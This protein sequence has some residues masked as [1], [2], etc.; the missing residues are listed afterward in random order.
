MFLNQISKAQQYPT[1]FL[2]EL[3]INYYQI[4]IEG[5]ARKGGHSGNAYICSH[6]RPRSLIKGLASCW[7]CTVDIF[8][9][10]FSNFSNHFSWA[11]I[12][13][14]KCF[15]WDQKKLQIKSTNWFYKWE[16]LTSFQFHSIHE[17]RRNIHVQIQ[18]QVHNLTMILL[19]KLVHVCITVQRVQKYFLLPK[20][21]ISPLHFVYWNLQ[22]CIS[23]HKNTFPILIQTC[24]NKVRFGVFE[25]EVKHVITKLV[26][27]RHTW[28]SIHKLPIYQVLCVT[29][30]NLWSD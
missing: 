19:N 20:Q 21:Q 24:Y 14:W 23:I 9:I 11:R 22:M 3:L 28:C 27:A 2:K 6:F 26:Q 5:C 17:L 30:W 4:L 25:L 18:T 13:C 1:S 29:Y 8:N 12:I 15:P 10:P 7:Y 16:K